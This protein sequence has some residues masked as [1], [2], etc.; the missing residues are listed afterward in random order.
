MKYED[1][2]DLNYKPN[3]KKEIIASF[4]FEPND[5]NLKKVAGAI[6]AESSTGTWSEVKE[7][8]YV[9]KIS[10]KVFELKK[11]FVKI[12]YPL[13][14]FELGNLPNLLSSI[15]GNI[16]GMK[17][18]K[19]LKLLDVQFPR[20]Y[21]KS[22]RGPKFGI[23]GIRK[24]LKIKKR[25]LIG[26]IVKPK[27]GLNTKDF[28][29]VAYEAWKG[30]IDIVKDDE[31][32]ASQNFNKFEKRI[33]LVLKAKEKAEKETGEV[34]GYLANVT[35]ETFEMIK[36]AYLL[37][38]FG[39]NYMMVDILTIGFSALQTLRNQEFNLALHA[40]RAMHA[41]ITRNPKH[42]ISMY[43]I[44]KISR[45]VGVDQIHTGT[46]GIGKMKALENETELC[47]EFL[48]SEWFRV[49]K[50][51]PVASGGLHPG[52][53]PALVK[54][55][56]NDIVIQAGGGIH[57]HPKGTFAGAKAMREVVEGL[58]EGYTTK[59]IAKKSEEVRLAIKKWGYRR[60][61]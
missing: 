60:V 23:K 17:I 47:N 18:V 36:R 1:Y 5:K 40:H 50:V 55:L 30:G 29:K 56:G 54:K 2:V 35:S 43:F 48:R 31:N 25:P 12:A 21:V 7:N 6:A 45:L 13:E 37:E 39:N 52:L 42:G 46:A 19:N 24:M 59:E 32:L 38:E 61:K 28:A 15:A 14:L 33:E 11:N 8:S 3:P 51:L 58:I 44:A 27:V 34:K 22:F 20:K 10:A 26:T 16:F 41:A 49:R 53:I 57:A 9:K 4:Y